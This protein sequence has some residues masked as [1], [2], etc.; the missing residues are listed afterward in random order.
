MICSLS[1][2]ETDEQRDHCEDTIID[3]PPFPDCSANAESTWWA[4]SCGIEEHA[5]SDGSCVDSLHD[6]EADNRGSEPEEAHI[7]SWL[8][9]A[10]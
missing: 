4:E 2:Y 10:A 1:Q 8:S 6:D 9:L 7:G 5:E 3:R